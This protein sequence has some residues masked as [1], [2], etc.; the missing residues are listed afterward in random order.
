MKNKKS[1][2][3]LW[4][5]AAF[6]AASP[7]NAA[8]LLHDT[9]TA[10]GQSDDVNSGINGSGRQTGALAGTT[11]VQGSGSFGATPGG[12]N[13]FQTQVNNGGNGKLWLVGMGG[14]DTSS[15]SL[16]HN[17]NEN[18]G[19]GGYTTISFDFN[20]DTAGPSSYWG[21]I[22]IGAADNA[23]FGATGSGARGKF[24]NSDSSHF[25]IL[26]KDNGAYETFDGSVGNV[27][28]GNGSF[29]LDAGG[30]GTHHY[31]MR[32][33]DLVD[34]HAWDGSG[35]TLIQLFRDGAASPFF[36]FTKTGGYT[37]NFI[38]LQGW[39]DGFTIHEF[40]NLHIEIVPEPSGAVLAGAFGTLLLFRRMRLQG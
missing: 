7:A 28:T 40:D 12:G 34:G 15:V 20:P 33:S 27:G 39:S 16:N 17:F 30:V 6:A 8:V 3:A 13:D 18:A 4:C 19:I 21:G 1:S 5:V 32:I 24:I 14:T 36:S 29:A 25:G 23:A 9:F 22:T 31:E 38:T 11:Y 26:F 2:T 10:S 35:N 37:D